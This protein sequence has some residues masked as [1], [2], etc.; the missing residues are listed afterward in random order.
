MGF[1][2]KKS[3]SKAIIGTNEETGWGCMDYYKKH[4]DPPAYSFSPDGMYTVVNRE[5][6]TL[7]ADFAKEI[8]AGGPARSRP[9][10]P[11]TRQIRRGRGM[12]APYGSSK[13]RRL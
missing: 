3:R 9:A 6:G 7:G 4:L 1:V 5:K 12:A 11:G 8:E 2:P 10:R 13:H